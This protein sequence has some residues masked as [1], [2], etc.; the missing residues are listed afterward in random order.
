[1][2]IATEKGSHRFEWKH[3]KAD[4]SFF[5]AEVTLSIV[6]LERRLVMYCVWRDLTLPK[7]ADAELKK[8]EAQFLAL[9]TMSSDWFWSQGKEFRF[10]EFSG[11]FAND[12]T[13][14]SN[15]IGKTRWELSVVL[16]PDQWA[17]H[18]AILNAN[19]P[20]R[21]FE[22]PITG[23][24]GEMRWYSINGDPLFDDADQ[25]IGYHGTGRNITEYKD[26][27][28]QIQ[29]LAF[30]DPLTGLPNRRLLIDRLKHALASANRHQ[31]KGALL[32]ID[33]D[34]F[35]IINDTLGHD[36]GD[37]LLQQVA[38][39]LLACVRQ[40]DTV[41]RLGGDEFIRPAGRLEPR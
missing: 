7:Q 20:F 24:D 3:R 21:N 28:N 39:R 15:T 13:P 8:R 17:A 32:L 18:R 27:L 16:T 6:E 25:F 2:A 5:E 22:Y 19:L 9:S 31:R 40:S 36:Q 14:P 35:K 29:S 10:T 30:S 26:A 4:G 37:L 11:A 12:F 41:A 34:D 1:M 38:S 33:L 23:D